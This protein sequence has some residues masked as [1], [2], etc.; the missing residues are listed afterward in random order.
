LLIKS[1]RSAIEIVKVLQ[2]KP[3]YVFAFITACQSL[4]ILGQCQRQ[5]DFM[6]SP[7]PPKP[8]QKQSLFSKILQKLRGE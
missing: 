1:P 3:Q 8:S 4:G 5:A 6:V 7:E 2:V